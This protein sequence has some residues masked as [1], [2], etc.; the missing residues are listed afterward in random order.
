MGIRKR[1]FA[2]LTEQAMAVVQWS[3]TTQELE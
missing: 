1:L 3:G 2:A